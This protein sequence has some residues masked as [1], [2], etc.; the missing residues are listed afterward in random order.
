MRGLLEL[1]C[2]PSIYARER[3]RADIK[4]IREMRGGVRLLE[5]S[6]PSRRIVRPVLK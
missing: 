2:L 5:A 3:S 4:I 6:R 1:V